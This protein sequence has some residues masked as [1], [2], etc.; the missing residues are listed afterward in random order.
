MITCSSLSLENN[1]FREP[2]KSSAK[3]M[4]TGT[5]KS[6]MKILVQENRKKFCEN[7][8]LREPKKVPEKM[9]RENYPVTIG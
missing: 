9:F 2:K 5:E 6:S 4:F 7:Y 1:S 3:F 8:S